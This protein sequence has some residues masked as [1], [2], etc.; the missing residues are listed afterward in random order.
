MKKLIFA[1]IAICL[2]CAGFSFDSDESS[3][4]S[5]NSIYDYQ[6]KYIGEEMEVCSSSSSKTYMDYRSINNI[7]SRQY[8]FITNYMTVDQET[9]FLL[10]DEGFIGVALGTYFGTIGDRFYFTLDTGVV[11]PLVMVDAK[12]DSHTYNGCVHAVDS[13]VIEFVIDNQIASEYFGRFGNGLILQGNFNNYSLF[14]GEIVRV[15][16]VTDE[17]NSDYITYFDNNNQN[18]TFDIFQYASGY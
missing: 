18:E 3:S 16:K 9:G 7:R 2:I 13:S 5:L 6:K 12:S 11:L 14:R 10:D 4:F 8:K 15:E 17:L 1:V